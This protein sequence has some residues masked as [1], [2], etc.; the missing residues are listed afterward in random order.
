MK[1]RKDGVLLALVKHNF[2]VKAMTGCCDLVA[3]KDNTL[4]LAKV[5]EDANA[6]TAEAAQELT[7]TAAALHAAPLIIS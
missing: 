2:T 5:L 3:R 7:K 1:N 6:M 4:L